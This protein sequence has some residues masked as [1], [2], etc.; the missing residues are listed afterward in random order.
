M[1]IKTAFLTTA[2]E[3]FTKGEI[4]KAERLFTC[5]P[6]ELQDDE[7]VRLLKSEIWGRVDTLLNYAQN[8]RTEDEHCHIDDVLGFP[9]FKRAVELIEGSRL[10]ILDVGCYTG[11]FLQ[12]MQKLGHKCTGVDVH[13]NIKIPKVKYVYVAAEHMNFKDEFDVVTSFDSLEHSFCDESVKERMEDACKE[14]GLIIVHL[15]SMTPGYK[16]EAFEHLRMYSKD[17]IVG[18]FGMEKHFIL[19]DCEDEHGNKTFLIHY[20][21]SI[22]GGIGEDS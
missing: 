4:L 20:E 3:L 12:H 16:D 18:M 19:E 9:K 22:C 17:D 8:G 6:L 14:G 10:K 21:N 15:P 7:D 1:D 2:S 13:T 5:L 11:G